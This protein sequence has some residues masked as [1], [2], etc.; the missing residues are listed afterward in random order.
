MGRVLFSIAVA[1]TL[2]LG[3]AACAEKEQ[4]GTASP[5]A[6]AAATATPAA[7]ETAQ[8]T[9]TPTQTATPQRPT[10]PD[11]GAI[12]RLADPNA[13]NVSIR[14]F[15][16]N[17][18]PFAEL[19]YDLEARVAS[20][21]IGAYGGVTDSDRRY[22]EVYHWVDGSWE[23]VFNLYEF[24]QAIYAVETLG[25]VVDNRPQAATALVKG[26]LTPL[27]SE[28]PI[29]DLLFVET[30]LFA[31]PLGLQHYS[32]TISALAWD[33]DELRVLFS[34]EFEVRGSMVSVQSEDGSVILAV[35]AYLPSDPMCCPSGWEMLRLVSD[36]RAL[37]YLQ[38]E[39]RCVGPR[40]SS[41]LSP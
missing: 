11:L 28:G 4:A 35:D 2:A 9:T 38:P 30:G 21:G 7:T 25:P 41:C 27:E 15:L 13:K 17:G 5:T 3:V 16:L 8:A 29:G 26:V 12:P 20:P 40:N 34:E 10:G 32:P 39:E 22:V 6:T 24:V 31:G 18:E 14:E 37:R 19:A 23:Q 1:F 36:V 33:D